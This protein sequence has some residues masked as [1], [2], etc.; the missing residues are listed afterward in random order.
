MRWKRGRSGGKAGC[1]VRGPIRESPTTG[2]SPLLTAYRTTRLDTQAD[3]DEI[4]ESTYGPSG[5]SCELVM[6]KLQV[7]LLDLFR[8]PETYSEPPYHDYWFVPGSFLLVK[9]MTDH[10]V[11][12]ERAPSGRLA[13]E[14]RL[15]EAT[16]RLRVL[17]GG[18]APSATHCFC[19]NA[20]ECYP[21]N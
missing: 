1:R 4:L 20:I 10:I 18:P 5:F 8:S 11:L 6:N 16:R 13:I 21:I 15:R 12:L 7:P 14:R 17:Q 19:F 9:S 2:R 3:K